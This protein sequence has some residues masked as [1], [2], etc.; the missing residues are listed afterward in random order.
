MYDQIFLFPNNLWLVSYET[1]V[2]AIFFQNCT[3]EIT[4]YVKTKAKEEE[5]ICHFSHHNSCHNIFVSGWI[6]TILVL[7]CFFYKALSSKTIF[8]ALA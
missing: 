4:G 1:E 3:D 6:L 7:F 5:K 8:A 2:T